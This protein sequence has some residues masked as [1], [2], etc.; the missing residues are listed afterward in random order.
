M[1]SVG[2]DPELMLNRDGNLISALKHVSGRKHSPLSLKRGGSVLADNVNVE[3]NHSPAGD[4]GDFVDKIRTALE[5][6]ST[7]VPNARLLARAAAVFPEAQMDDEE[8]HIF[9]CDPEFNAWHNGEMVFPPFVADHDFFRSCGG[10]IHIGWEP[11]KK[12]P[13]RLIQS[14]D[15]FVG[16]PLV[17][18][19]HDETSG[20]RHRLY[21]GAGKFRPTTYGAEYRTPSNYWMRHPTLAELVFQLTEYAVAEIE[22]PASADA[23]RAVQEND[24]RLATQ[25]FERLVAE[26]LPKFIA[27]DI[28]HNAKNAI[29]EDVL[30]NWNIR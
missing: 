21:G 1:I 11:A 16:V 6:I 23:M 28:M 19:D 15:L 24:A 20:E 27:N 25:V 5:D 18:M 17:I 12:N 26:R 13:L 10:H 2:S 29:G 9:G 8:A 14:M 4:P 3:F 7:L 22:A 30:E